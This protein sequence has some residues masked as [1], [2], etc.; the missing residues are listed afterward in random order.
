MRSADAG[1]RGVPAPAQRRAPPRRPRGGAGSARRSR[2]RI[3]R[4]SPNPRRR[5]VQ[6]TRGRENRQPAADAPRA[7][8]R[9]VVAGTEQA[10][11]EEARRDMRLPLLDPAS[12]EPLVIEFADNILD[13]LGDASGIN[14]TDDERLEDASHSVELAGVTFRRLSSGSCLPTRPSTRWST[15]RPPSSRRRRRRKPADYAKQVIRTFC[16]FRTMWIADFGGSGSPVSVEVDHRF[17]RKWIA[18]GRTG[19]PSFRDRERSSVA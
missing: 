9:R 5:S 1:R 17:R 12:D 15:R 8:R 7:H 14:V 16:V 3:P 6:R 2:R 13:F 10:I 19:S 11:R 4:V 18:F